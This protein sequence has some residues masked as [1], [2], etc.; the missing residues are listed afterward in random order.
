MARLALAGDI[1]ALNAILNHPGV[2]PYIGEGEALDAAKTP[3]SILT[4]IEPH[5]AI[6]F[7]PVQKGTWE[8]HTAFLPQARGREGLK[9]AKECASAMFETFGAQ[10]LVTYTPRDC[11]HARPP[12]S[13][14]FRQTGTAQN[15]IRGVS[16]TEYTLTREEWR[17]KCQQQQSSAAQ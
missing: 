9:M 1:P 7:V 6:L 17:R 8:F 10:E 14:G 5:R 16:A 2:L 4:F 13:M 15:Y 3:P 12:R 11:P